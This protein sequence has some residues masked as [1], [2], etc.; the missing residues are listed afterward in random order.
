MSSGTLIIYFFLF[1]SFD[2]VLKELSENEPKRI[3]NDKV[4][5]TTERTRSGEIR[6]GRGRPVVSVCNQ[7]EQ[8]SH[9]AERHEHEA[10]D[11]VRSNK[12]RKKLVSVS[13]QNAPILG[14]SMKTR[15]DQVRH[16]RVL[17][18]VLP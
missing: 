5:D 7:P 1:R 6:H 11:M 16:G 9:A 2:G 13:F 3:S 18:R 12:T 10:Y 4:Q 8:N 14:Y 15:P 17:D